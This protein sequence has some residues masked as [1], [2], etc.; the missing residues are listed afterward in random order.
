MVEPRPLTKGLSEN[1][2]SEV[3]YAV[4]PYTRGTYISSDDSSLCKLTP[5]DVTTHLNH[6]I[7]KRVFYIDLT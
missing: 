4:Y 1:H 2:I 6:N 3:L 7:Y 5:K